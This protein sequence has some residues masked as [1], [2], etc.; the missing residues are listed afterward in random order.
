MIH[1][2]KRASNRVPKLIDL[3]AELSGIEKV[4]SL[5]IIN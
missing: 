1:A 4:S 3:I 5:K 2:T